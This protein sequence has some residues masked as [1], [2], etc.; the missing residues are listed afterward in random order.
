MDGLT[1]WI[2]VCAA[3]QNA[4]RPLKMNLIRETFLEHL[5]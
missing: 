3:L 2:L 1:S 4:V 5:D